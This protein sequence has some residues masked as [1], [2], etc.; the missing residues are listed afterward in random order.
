MAIPRNED[1]IMVPKDQWPTSS[2]NEWKEGDEESE[3]I[4][5]SQ[6]QYQ[7]EGHDEAVKAYD[8]SENSEDNSE[9]SRSHSGNEDPDSETTIICDKTVKDAKE[10]E[11]IQS[12]RESTP[13][14]KTHSIQHVANDMWYEEEEGTWW[15]KNQSTTKEGTKERKRMGEKGNPML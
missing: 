14:Q 12:V 11:E 3:G 10:D 2:V 5:E 6:S 8:I 9:K 1:M 13:K 7:K 4:T 15:Y